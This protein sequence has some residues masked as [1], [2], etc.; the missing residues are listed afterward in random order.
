M[1]KLMLLVSLISIVAFFS[2][3]SAGYVSEEPTY[4]ETARPMRP[5]SNYVW[6]EGDW[7]WNNQTRS[8]SHQNGRWQAPNGGREYKP[9]H[10]DNSPRG[11][12]WKKGH[13]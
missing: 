6:I 13:R 7:R 9:G 5:A 11:Y 4:I 12:K 1:K 2:S 8:Y 10:W 3:C